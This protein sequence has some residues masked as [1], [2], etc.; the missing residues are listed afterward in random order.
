MKSEYNKIR[1]TKER[2]PPI[3]QGRGGGVEVRMRGEM[4][5]AADDARNAARGETREL[6]FR[7]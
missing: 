5:K 4:G 2:P 1:V 6:E 3:R 7:V